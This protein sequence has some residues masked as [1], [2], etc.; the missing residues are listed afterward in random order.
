M[1]Q[2]FKRRVAALLAGATMAGVVGTPRS[3]E[4][5]HLSVVVDEH[6]RKIYINLPEGPFGSRSAGA[7][8]SFTA[9]RPSPDISSV[10]ERTAGRFQLDPNLI[11][12]IIRVESGFDPR[13]VSPKGALGLM[14]LI[15]ATAERFGVRNPFDARENIEGGVTYLN[16]LLNRFRGDVPLSLAAYNAGEN[17]VLRAHGIPP[18]R[19]TRRYV[20][21]VTS[22]YRAGSRLERSGAKP[23]RALSGSRRNRLQDSQP[24]RPV[25]SAAPI[26]RYVDAAGVIHFEQ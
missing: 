9:A 4:A 11:H 24:A 17:S 7:A 18:I 23:G 22:L 13:A 12:A 20:A 16:Y 3:A 6:G 15:P 8:S 5:A 1:R 21:K 10:I 14:Q 26:Y 19:E 2:T 25:A